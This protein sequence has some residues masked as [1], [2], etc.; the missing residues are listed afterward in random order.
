MELI[1]H[2]FDSKYQQ[3]ILTGYPSLDSLIGGIKRQSLII[4]AGA[5]GMGKSLLLMNILIKLAKSGV[6]VAYFD[7][8]NGA[9]LMA[10]RFLMIWYGLTREYFMDKTNNEDAH[11]KWEEIS[12]KINLFNHEQLYELS[13]TNKQDITWNIINLIRGSQADVVAIDPLQAFE[14][15]IP[16]VEVIRMQTDTT[17]KFKELAQKLNTSIIICHHV[18]KSQSGGGTWIEDIEDVHV[19]KYRVPT[20]DDLKGSSGITQYATDVWAMV[21]TAGHSTK[22][23]RG[24]TFFRVLKARRGM[25][26]DI[27]DLYLDEDTLQF[28]DQNCP[29]KTEEVLQFFGEDLI[30]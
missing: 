27:R 7:L 10:Q 19:V 26:G 4:L 16:E 21:R 22:E 20:I 3:G 24:K 11:R 14:T 12:G 9:E 6:R 23:G 13:Y 5:T 8:E 30:A 28:K 29:A 2:L 18:R 1:D 15:G 25:Q 17:K